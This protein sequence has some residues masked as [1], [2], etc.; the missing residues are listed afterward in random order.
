MTEKL[1]SPCPFCGCKTITLYECL[2]GFE[3][4]CNRCNARLGRQS[5][6]ALVRAWNKRVGE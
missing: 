2:G 6:Q 3:A 4:M 1:F 5:I